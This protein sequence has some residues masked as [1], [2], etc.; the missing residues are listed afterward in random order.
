MRKHEIYDML[1]EEDIMYEFPRGTGRSIVRAIYLALIN[2]A[3]TDERKPSE[4]KILKVLTRRKLPN[5]LPTI[6]DY[7]KE[8]VLEGEEIVGARSQVENG[9]EEDDADVA[10][11]ESFGEKSDGTLPTGGARG[12]AGDLIGTVSAASTDGRPDQQ[13]GAEASIPGIRN[14]LLAAMRRICRL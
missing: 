14:F 9:I 10:G 8:H 2:F 1:D 3:R 11:Q 5:V 6:D 4:E 13:S 12:D 7:Y